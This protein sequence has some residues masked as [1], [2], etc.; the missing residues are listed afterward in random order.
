MKDAPAI[1]VAISTLGRPD[2][3]A[4]CLT[5]LV[6]GTTLPA[7][8]AIVDQSPSGDGAAAAAAF[9]DS[10]PLV[11]EQQDARGLARGQNRAVELTTEPVFAVIDDDC[12]AAPE[13]LETVARTL[14]DDELAGMAGR[15]LPLGPEAPGLVPVSLRTSTLRRD[16]T[17]GALPWDVG[18]GNNFALRRHWFDRIGGCDTRLGPGSPGRGAVDIDLFHRILQ[19]GGRM[20]YEP[21]AVV[22]HERK[23]QRDRLTRRVSYGHGMGAACGLWLRARDGDA[24]RVLQS[25]LVLR[26]RLL[27]GELRRGHVR[28]LPE[29]TIVVGSTLIGLAHG[30]TRREQQELR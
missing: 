20:R 9:A 22:Y 24:R 7:T 30:L 17:T 23:S 27:A 12:V 4:R 18:S 26:A 15:V 1:A 8:V 21:D 2:A 29:E 28:A 25:W 10:L 11:V 5:S 13:W 6:E 16:L 14:G 3:L 19:A